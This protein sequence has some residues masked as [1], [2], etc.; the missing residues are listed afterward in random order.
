MI[1]LHVR[2]GDRHPWEYQYQKS[3]IP[4]QTYIDVAHIMLDKAFPSPKH[5][6]SSSSFTN[7]KASSKFLLA[8]DDPDV[9]TASE[10][11]AAIRAQETIVLASKDTLDAAARP[12]SNSAPGTFVEENVGWEGGF[13]QDVFWNLGRPSSSLPRTQTTTITA[14]HESIPENIHHQKPGELATQLRKL[15]GRAY[16]LDLAV[17]SKSDRI[18]CAVSSTTCRLLAVMMGWK[19]VQRGEWRNVDG[20]FEWSGMDDRG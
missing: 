19:R 20:G 15:V 10:F 18:V 9:Y 14:N 13:F 11:S 17:L 3:Y 6:F 8:S 4:Y 2:R 1:G 5:F 12:I 7:A 16:L